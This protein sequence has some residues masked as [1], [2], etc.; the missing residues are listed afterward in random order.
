MMRENLHLSYQLGNDRLTATIL[1]DLGRVALA[2]QRI[3]QAVE[4][5]QKSIYLLCEAVESPDLSMHRLYL[6]KCFAARP[7]FHAARDQFRQVIQ[8]GQALDKFFLVYWG[9]V[10]IART[11]L[12]EGQIEKA[13]EIS[14]LL[15]PYPTEF[16]GIE[17]ESVRLLADLQAALPEGQ[18]EAALKQVDGDISPD[19]AR[20]DVLAFVLEHEIG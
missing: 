10:S 18:L 2:T 5:I 17:A 16:S 15:R 3:E 8:A 6:G 13:L 1:F 19:Q 7:D 4:Y 14:L 11:Y 12:V 20:A 9:L